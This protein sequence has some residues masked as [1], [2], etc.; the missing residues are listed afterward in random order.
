MRR[1][2]WRQMCPWPDPPLNQHLMHLIV[3]NQA[4]SECRREPFQ[5]RFVYHIYSIYIYISISGSF[6]PQNE[7]ESK[8]TAN[9]D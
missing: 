9:E 4:L 1:A 3:L 5:N 2:I 8:C 7:A 6:L